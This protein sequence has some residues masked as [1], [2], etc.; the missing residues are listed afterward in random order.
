VYELDNDTRGIGELEF[1][2]NFWF[3]RVYELDNDT[4][5]IREALVL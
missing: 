3:E 4:K 1:L 2:E 5:G